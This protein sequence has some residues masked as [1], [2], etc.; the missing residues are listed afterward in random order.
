MRTGKLILLL[1][2]PGLLSAPFAQKTPGEAAPAAAVEKKSATP[3]RKAESLEDFEKQLQKELDL[4]PERAIATGDQPSV[5][6]QFIRT[7]LTLGILL[8]IFYA[9]FRLYRFRRTLPAQNFT[10]MSSIY[11]FPL[12]TGQKVQILEIA[13]RLMILGVSE[14][15]VQL[16]SEVTDKYTVDRIKLDCAE[17][18][19]QP[20]ADFLTELS[21]AIK[22]NLKERFGKK[23]GANFSASGTQAAE[24]LEAQR[25]NSLK[26]L[27]NL[28]SEKFDWRD[29][30]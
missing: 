19:K 21:R 28:K 5:A 22:T 26:R 7:L 10:A 30:L 12:G 6:W 1:L 2:T 15:S 13:G 29:K 4:N 27:R 8:G 17:D 20:R 9:I 23:S 18:S 16:L 3:E 14:N 25:E 24:D 11:E